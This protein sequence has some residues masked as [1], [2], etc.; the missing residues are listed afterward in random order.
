MPKLKFN[1]LHSSGKSLVLREVLPQLCCTPLEKAWASVELKAGRECEIRK[2]M[3][4]T[5]NLM[6]MT[7]LQNG[8]AAG[9]LFRK[10]N[11]EFLQIFQPWIYLTVL[12]A[13]QIHAPPF[14]NLSVTLFQKNSDT[15]NCSGQL[16]INL[17]V[18]L[19]GASVPTVLEEKTTIHHWWIIRRKG[20]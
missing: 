16:F 5:W 18:W 11:L 10:K 12:F 2:E 7:N 8:R 19:P 14:F 6:L 13:M 1:P 20:K 15:K 4:M 17:Q 9:E 3:M